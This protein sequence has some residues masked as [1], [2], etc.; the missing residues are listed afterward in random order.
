MII[1]DNIIFSLQKAGGI[2]VVW[3]E[4]IERL[5]KDYSFNNTEMLFLEYKYAKDNLF[6]KNI[7]IPQER[8][9]ENL[10]KSITLQRYFNPQNIYKDTI[11]FHSSYYRTMKN[12]RNI[13]TIHDFT[14]EF[15]RSGLQKTV[16]TWQ[17]HKALLNSEKIICISYN[18]KNDLLKLFPKINENKIAVVYNGVDECFY[19]LY[20]EEKETSFENQ[21]YL[22]YVGDR[23]ASYKQFDLAIQTA[24]EY[25][26]PLVIVGKKLY[27]KEIEKL[28]GINYQIITGADSKKLNRIYN[29]AF[30]LL[31]PSLYEGFGLPIIEAQKAGCPVIA[32]NNSSIPE[33]IGKNGLT[34]KELNA[35]NIVE[36]LKALENNDFRTSVIQDGLN[37]AKR[38]SWD[39]TYHETSEIYK[40]LI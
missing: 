8:I 37:N 22:L 30:C 14:Y 25:N 34:L 32:G 39:K 29:A 5:L 16:H 36:V 7:H 21:E 19:P 17:K 4:H 26:R 33:V 27:K 12:A 38:F 31:Y 15:F 9:K 1:L 35:H 3:K 6:R 28:E 18:T 24:K 23:I 13:T 40:S 10:K 20:L 11:L 2:S